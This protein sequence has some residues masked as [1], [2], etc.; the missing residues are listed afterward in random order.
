MLMGVGRTFLQFG[1]IVM[2]IQSACSLEIRKSKHLTQQQI[3][4]K[5]TLQWN[6]LKTLWDRIA[7][8]EDIDSTVSTLSDEVNALETDIITLQAHEEDVANSFEQKCQHLD[9][10]LDPDYDCCLS[11]DKFQ[12]YCHSRGFASF[13]GYDLNKGVCSSC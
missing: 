9:T 7:S 6:D 10:L 11:G 4:N 1:L 3:R 12:L 8:A 13:A 5:F 2:F